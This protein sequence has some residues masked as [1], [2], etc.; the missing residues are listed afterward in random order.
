MSKVL[1]VDDKEMMRDSVATTLSRRGHT[2]VSASG[3]KAAGS[4]RQLGGMSR[5]VIA[6]S[7]GQGFPC[8]D[9]FTGRCLVLFASCQATSVG[10]EVAQF[11][12]SCVWLCLNVV[13]YYF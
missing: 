3:G 7:R 5:W 13:D 11:Y 10:S 1:V 4:A 8:H 2:V 6:N 9:S 12:L